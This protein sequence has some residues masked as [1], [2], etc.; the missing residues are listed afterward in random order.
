LSTGIKHKHANN[1]EPAASIFRVP[2]KK[3]KNGASRAI[4]KPHREPLPKKGKLFLM[5]ENEV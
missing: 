1:E 5:K 4:G 2:E 3:R